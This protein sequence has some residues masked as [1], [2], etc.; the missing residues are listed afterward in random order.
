MTKY[1]EYAVYETLHGLFKICY[2]DDAITYIKF[3]TESDRSLDEKPTRLTDMAFK[4]LQEYFKGERKAFDL[5][6]LF[7]GTEFQKKVW[8][9]LCE[10]PYGET[11]SYKQIAIAV[12]NPKASRAIGM[13]NNKNPITVVVPCHRVV[14]SNGSLVGYA[15]GLER[16]TAFLD[17][18]SNN[19]FNNV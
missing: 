13:A 6:L 4:Q 12:G 1:G 3:A 8:R 5:P 2:I 16:K 10:I 15:G 18:E 19:L 17:I 14:G 11:R 9:A 7:I